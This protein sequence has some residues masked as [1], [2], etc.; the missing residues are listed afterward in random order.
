MTLLWSRGQ[1]RWVA[2]FRLLAAL[3]MALAAF[4]IVR[5]VVLAAGDPAGDATIAA[6]HDAGVNF[7]W[8]LTSGALVFFMQAGFALLGAGLIRA[9]NTVNYL[10]KNILDF[11]AAGLSFWAF[12]YA[13]MFGGSGLPGLEEGNAFIGFSGFFL[14][15]DAYDVSTTSFWFFQMVFAATT[16]TIVAGAVAERTKVTAYLAYGFLVTALIYPIYGHWMWGGGWLGG[17]Q[18]ESWVGAAAVDF[19]GSAWCTR[20][21]ACWLWPA[22]PPWARGWASTGPTARCAAFRVT[23]WSTW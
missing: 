15:R 10:T 3:A 9:K 20:S 8:T 11:A 23:T 12:G 14:V 18:L 22:R 16:A 17:E 7:V 19:A 6:D 1:P 5:G 21:A 13:F 2:T 4:L